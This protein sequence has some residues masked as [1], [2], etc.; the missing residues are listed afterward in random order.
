MSEHF[1]RIIK[2][3]PAPWQ[4][5]KFR[6]AKLH[7]VTDA[8]TGE[9]SSHYNTIYDVFKSRG[10]K[11]W[12]VDDLPSPRTPRSGASVIS[13]ASAAAGTEGGG[14]GG[15]GAA[16]SS[17][18]VA[19]RGSATGRAGQS[20]SSTTTMSTSG[21]VAIGSGA[22][23]SASTT[24]DSIPG[25]VATSCSTTGTTPTAATKGGGSS[26]SA[27]PGTSGASGMGGQPISFLASSSTPPTTSPPG[28][29]RQLGG[30][31]STASG[32][33]SAVTGATGTSTSASAG[34][35]AVAAPAGTSAVS[36]KH[37]KQDWH[38][39]WADKDW[40]HG[41]LEKLHL[42][43][44][45]RVNHFR[46]HYELT[47]K[48]LLAKNVKRHK[49]ALEKEGSAQSLE[50]ARKYEEMIPIT[51]L[52]PQEYSMFVEEFRRCGKQVWIM[53]PV[54]R[55]QGT[56]IFMVTKLS[57]LA[58]WKP[59]TGGGAGGG[60][61]GGYGGAGAGGNDFDPDEGPAESYIVQK[62]I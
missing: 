20:A 3:D 12:G 52:L 41:E 35:G 14:T 57:Q 30:P 21:G 44:W 15:G 42:E 4:Q 22:G 5:I 29:A 36:T 32:G 8:V 34:G 53:K 11:E 60:G 45:Q 37:L 28:S 9:G 61:D 54:G 13:S 59:A 48:D 25:V 1:R 46:N 19:R 7:R 47:R 50:T 49:R 27:R 31:A 18:N 24:N 33:G 38:I 62:Y 43:P 58:N 23:A 17:S 2:R 10:W 56:G 40:I 39:H 55:S 16:A 51:F 6:C 26:V